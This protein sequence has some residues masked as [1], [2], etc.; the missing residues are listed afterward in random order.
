MEVVVMNR[1]IRLTML[2]GFV[3]ASPLL[4]FG[5]QSTGMPAPNAAQDNAQNQSSVTRA[6]QWGKGTGMSRLTRTVPADAYRA[7]TAQEQG[8]VRADDYPASNATGFAN[9][10]VAVQNPSD[11]AFRK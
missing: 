4:T 7:Q 3:L 5:G 1:S 9:E 10:L 2:S 11:T 6:V 8:V